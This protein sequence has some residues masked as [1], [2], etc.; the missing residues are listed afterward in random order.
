MYVYGLYDENVRQATNTTLHCEEIKDNSYVNISCC[1]T[2]QIS[3]L[4]DTPF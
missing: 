1:F 4:F 2:K 3:C